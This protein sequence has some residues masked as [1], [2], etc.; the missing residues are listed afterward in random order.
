[1][2]ASSWLAWMRERR[3]GA[4]GRI[5]ERTIYL[6]TGLLTLSS[7]LFFALLPLPRAYFPEFFVHRPEELAPALLFL[8]ALIGYL[9]KGD[10]RHDPFE[11]W[12]ML[13]LIVSFVGQAAF[14]SFSGRLFDMAFD[15]AHLLKNVSY[16]FVLTGLLISMLV[17]YR[18]AEDRGDQIRAVV[19]N[20]VDAI[21][22]INLHGSILS[23]NPGTTAIFGH[24]PEDAIGRN[25]KFLMPPPYR[26]E[27]DGYL[28]SY[29]RTGNAKII[30]IGREV[31]GLRKDGATFAMELAVSEVRR[32]GRRE[33][34]GI[35][36]DI[37]V[38]K[39][40]QEE[41]SAANKELESFAYSVSHDLR[42]PLRA[43]DGFSEA[44]AP[45]LWRHP[46]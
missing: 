34:V 46:R 27:H 23:F 31:M 20:A 19:D 42:A 37:S 7:F 24:S 1:M 4:A 44:L 38:R 45:G 32:G 8:V 5:G 22:T 41:L 26:E 14:M 17:I 6:G 25:V 10:W 2:Q 9:R 15:M 28:E 40:A 18:R 21:I 13:A 33:F 43:I 11:H 3:L 39:R 29:Q 36:R 16:V 30:G 35:C 12:M